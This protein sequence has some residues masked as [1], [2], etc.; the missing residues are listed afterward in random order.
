MSIVSSIARIATEYR[1]A[2]ARYMTERSI[3]GLSPEL[4]KDI[5]W[6]D[7]YVSRGGVRLPV[8]NNFR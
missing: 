2:R 4:Q 8:D 5:G 3:Q 1:H 7:I 6:P